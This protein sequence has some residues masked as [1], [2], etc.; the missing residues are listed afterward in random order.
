[1]PNL[2]KG[3]GGLG[4]EMRLVISRPPGLNCQRGVTALVGWSSP[5]V[6]LIGHNPALYYTFEPVITYNP[7]A[8][9]EHCDQHEVPDKP[10]Q[11]NLP[12]KNCGFSWTWQRFGDEG[13]WSG[14]LGEMATT[15]RM[16]GVCSSDVATPGGILG[17]LQMTLQPTIRAKNFHSQV[18]HQQS[19]GR[20]AANF[21][22]G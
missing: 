9:P 13:S 10:Q 22:V 4:K 16:P 11:G 6:Q 17:Y 19:T 7:D 3:G 18:N 5:R 21:K 2:P 8:D 1:M 14:R 20:L 15:G 12:T